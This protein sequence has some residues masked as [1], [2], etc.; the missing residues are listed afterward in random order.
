MYRR[1]SFYLTALDII[2]TLLALFAVSAFSYAGIN[3][4]R[5]RGT[6]SILC[7][8]PLKPE[9]NYEICRSIPWKVNG[10]QQATIANALSNRTLQRRQITLNV[11]P[12]GQPKPFFRIFSEKKQHTMLTPGR[13]LPCRMCCLDYY[14]SESCFKLARASGQVLLK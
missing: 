3:R 11:T 6:I 13:G 7:R 9:Q 8:I 5:F 14:C 2:S 4:I 12:E 10:K 1:G